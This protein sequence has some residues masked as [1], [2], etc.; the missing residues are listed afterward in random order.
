MTDD[1]EDE[2]GPY[3]AERLESPS[4]RRHF[5]RAERRF[6]LGHVFPVAYKPSQHRVGWRKRRR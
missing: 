4:F 5:E 6:E 2:F 1:F 3:L